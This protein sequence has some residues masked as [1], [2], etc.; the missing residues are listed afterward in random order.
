MF[1]FI[2]SKPTDRLYI[3]LFITNTCEIVEGLTAEHIICIC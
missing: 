2:E 1:K 3:Y